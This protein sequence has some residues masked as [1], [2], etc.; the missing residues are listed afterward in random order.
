[1]TINRNTN[2]IATKK[3]FLSALIITY[4]EEHNI[5]NVLS[6]L[7]FADEIIVVDSFST[8]ETIAIAATH[9]NVKVVQHHF[10]NFAAQ[11][12]HAISLA[13]HSWI[14]FLDADERLTAELKKEIIKTIH[15]KEAA[16]AY[17]CCR[18]FM[19]KNTKLQ[20]S[21]WQTDKIIRLFNKEKAQYDLAKIV[22]EKLTVNGKTG[23]LKNRLIHYSYRSYNDYKQKMNTYGK[24][25]AIEEFNKG[26]KPT[27][28]HFYARPV[29][30]FLYQYIMRMG[31]LDGKKGIIICYLNSY[32][33]FVRFQE[34]KKIRL[35]N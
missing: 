22:H 2:E 34:L 8:D 1:M 25:K 16:V 17:Y 13:N 15:Q 24:L 5:K 26:T 4:N 19:F 11:R 27:F 33:V 18:T 23:K 21:G 7:D 31:I 28:F 12:N 6:D 9:K 29:Y 20:F 32:S 10:E 35:N 3:T 14:L 30:Q